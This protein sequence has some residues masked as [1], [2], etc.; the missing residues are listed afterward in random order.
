MALVVALLTLP[1]IT[2]E[3]KLVELL[4]LALPE[5]PTIIRVVLEKERPVMAC[6]S[7][8]EVEALSLLTAAKLLTSKEVGET[9]IE[10][11]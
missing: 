9:M 3:V 5:K 11:I 7:M 2:E 1:T 6:L 10:A 8:I 4:M